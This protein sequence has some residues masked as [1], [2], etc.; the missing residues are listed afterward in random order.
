MTQTDVMTMARFLVLPGASELLDAF[1][2]IPP[3]KLRES[4]VLHVQAIAET[5]SD[6]PAAQHMPDPLLMAAQAVPAPEPKLPALEGRRK[7]KSADPDVQ[8]MELLLQ[9]KP[10]HLIA[11]ELGLPMS[12]VLEAKRKGAAAGLI[13]PKPKPKK[14]KNR[15]AM[16]LAD[17]DARGLAVAQKAANRRGLDLETYVARRSLSVTMAVEGQHIKAIVE[18]TKSDEKQIRDWLNAARATGM[19]VPYVT[20]DYTP[21]P[22]AEEPEP[23]SAEIFDLKPKRDP[24]DAFKG[25]FI[26]YMDQLDDR[27]RGGVDKGAKLMGVSVEQYLHRRREALVLLAQKKSII[28]VAKAIGV[29]RKQAENWRGRAQRA[30]VLDLTRASKRKLTGAPNGGEAAVKAAAMLMGITTEAYKAKRA[31]AM[32]LFNQNLTAREVGE[33]VGVSTKKAANWRTW[34]QTPAAKA[35]QG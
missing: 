12:Q 26:L 21:A 4:A 33:R 24:D 9:G 10:P 1:S 27:N 22:P 2:R 31:E 25:R 14:H 32:K 23:P 5:Y 15:F 3:G 28:E 20:S 11:E 34:S 29:S 18:A 35:A 19:T 30:G 13:F 17:F 8:A 16:T 6:A 7:P